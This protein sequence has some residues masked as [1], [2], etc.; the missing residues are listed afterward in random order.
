MFMMNLAQYQAHIILKKKKQK[1]KNCH[2]FLC[3]AIRTKCYEDFT[4]SKDNWNSIPDSGSV[5]GRGREADCQIHRFKI[6]LM[7]RLWFFQWSC[8]DVRVGL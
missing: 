2:L 4:T 6:Y 5:L 1:T 7:S 8:M 3:R